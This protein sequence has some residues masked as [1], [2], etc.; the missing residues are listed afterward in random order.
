[1]SEVA[2]KELEWYLRDH[3]FRQSNA[4]KSAFRKES[5]PSE[6]ISLYLRYRNAD[7]Q[8]LS[9]L[10]NLVLDS[11]IARKV[12]NQEG[13]ELVLPSKLARLQCAKCFYI[14]YLAEAE[15][16]ACLRCQH[17]NLHDFPKKKA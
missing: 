6:M 5:L 1:M 4:G 11:L 10:M 17:T 12:L 9:Q 7:S 2:I 8:Q 16:R 15:P 3:L 13:D 14:S